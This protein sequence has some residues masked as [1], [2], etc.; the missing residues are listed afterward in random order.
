MISTAV[1]LAGGLGTRL[2]GVLKGLPKPMAPI[3]DRPFLEYQMDFWISQGVTRF[4]LSIGYLSHIIIEHFGDS[5]HTASIEYIVEDELLGTGG[6]LLLAS[7][8]LTDTF[9]VLNG[10]TFFEVDLI[11]FIA[12]HK[13]N[14]SE[15]TLSIFK[16]N[17]LDRYMSVNLGDDGEII[18]FQSELNKLTA[19]ANGGVYLLEPSALKR[20]NC[21][22]YKKSSLEN[23]LLPKFISLGCCLYGFQSSG[24]FIDIGIPKDYYRAQKILKN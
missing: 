17:H 24:K 12:F 16:S 8:G 20:L 9:L 13:K 10:D 22:Q 23:D 5:Y 1:V 21:T 11:K 2:K 15:V 14:K 3:H 18:S 4:I 6:A 19:L 7:Q